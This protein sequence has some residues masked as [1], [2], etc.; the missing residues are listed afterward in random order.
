MVEQTSTTR[1]TIK[2][3]P[4]QFW[5]MET[6]GE[7]V[8]VLDVESPKNHTGTVKLWN[9]DFVAQNEL[10]PAVVS[11]NWFVNHATPLHA[12][13]AEAQL[14]AMLANVT[15]AFPTDA[16]R[17]AN[18]AKTIEVL[19]SEVQELRTDVGIRDVLLARAAE[20][21]SDAEEDM[22]YVM[23][24]AHD[25]RTQASVIEAELRKQAALA[26]TWHAAYFSL[27]TDYRAEAAWSAKLGGEL[28]EA[29]R[30]TDNW[31]RE[32]E[33][34]SNELDSARENPEEWIR[35]NA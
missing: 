12:S 6:N 34:L 20:F 3:A 9:W 15:T 31:I 21:F 29:R 1:E 14:E 22:A 25:A 24:A 19:Q 18:Q 23:N 13:M 17:L 2:P 11:T 33:R 27:M 7:R 28:A 32:A 26:G 8:E 10:G 30:G 35:D 5:I 16:Q 4:G